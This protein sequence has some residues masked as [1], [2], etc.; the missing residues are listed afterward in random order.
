[1]VLKLIDNPPPWP[2]GARCAVCFS[3]DMDAESL[4][5]LNFRDTARRRVVTSSALRYGPQRAIPRL[6]EIWRHFNIKQ[7]VFVPG[8]CVETYPEAI[9]LLVREGHEIGHHGWL[10]EKP[11]LLSRDQEAEILIRGIEVIEKATG[12]RPLGYRAP[13]YA[14]SEHTLELLIG[15]GFTYDAS[16]LGDEVPYILQGA[17]GDLVELPS[18]MALDDWPQYVSMKEFGYQMPVQSPERAFDVFRAEFDAAFDHGGLWISVWHPF[19]SGRLARAAEMVKLID[20]MQSRGDV[21]FAPLADIAAYVNLL[22]KTGTWSPR[23][24]GLPYWTDPVPHLVP[25]PQ[26]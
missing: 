11:N 22:R 3:F 24:D 5:H 15:E 26:S 10:H 19:V 25:L 2:D 1:M 16:L 4:L 21:W 14:F 8:W 18:D 17:A 6:V 7:T 13:S 23:V 9:E 20:Y 12:K